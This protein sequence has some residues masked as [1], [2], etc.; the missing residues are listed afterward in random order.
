MGGAIIGPAWDGVHT[1]SE[2]LGEL[3]WMSCKC[4][5]W[6]HAQEQVCR[7]L[8]RER[9]LTPLLSSAVETCYRALGP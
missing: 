8:R 6:R 9:L 4:V 5:G 1:G 2:P 3:T 7:Q